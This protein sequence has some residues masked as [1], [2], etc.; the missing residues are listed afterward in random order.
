MKYGELKWTEV[1]RMDKSRRVVVLPL[2]S[3]EQHGHHLPLLTDTLIGAEIARRVEEALPETV[4]LTP[5]QWLGAS[6]HHMTFP[7]TL[8]LPTDMYIDVVCTLCECILKAGFPRI[9][10]LLSHGG[11]DVP[12]Q[13]VLHRMAIRHRD[14]DDFWIAAAGYWAVA[15]DALQI[16][17]MTT[18][19]PTHAC[20]YETSMILSIREDLVDLPA[21]RG[22]TMRLESKFYF[23][24]MTTR[25]GNK[26][27]FALP[28][29]Q[30]TGTGAIGRP[31]LGTAEKGEK[32]YAAAAARVVEFLRE[33]ADWPRPRRESSHA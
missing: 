2:A 9:F 30:M 3:L 8:S 14:R 7:G 19:R 33:F 1:Q 15:D 25:R 31:D 32:L 22:E 10:L 28:F 4:L 5:T 27:H 20:E 23:P 13:E 11:N 29:E 26:V 12:C 18:A 21:A 16:P 17:E 6:H 24:D